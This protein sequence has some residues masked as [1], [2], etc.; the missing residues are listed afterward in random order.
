MHT[1]T[2]EDMTRQ[3]QRLLD[4]ARSGELS[5]VTQA[6]EP[7]LLTVPLSHGAQ[8]QVQTQALRADLA[9]H[10]FDSDEIGLGMAAS[11]AGLS[12]TAM[13]DELSRRQIA[14]VRYSADELAA[15]LKY[16]DTLAGR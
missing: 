16:V 5:L 10:L 4:D 11:I 12:H 6:G 2:A 13:L 3:P 9:A 1:L 14:V 15:E 8:T 7:V